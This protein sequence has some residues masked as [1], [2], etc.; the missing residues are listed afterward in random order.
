MMSDM[1]GKTVGPYRIAQKLG[2]GGMGVVYLAEHTL[3]G[4]RAAVKMLLPEFSL[5][6]D[7]VTR[8]FNEARAAT[9]IRHPG[10]VE[11]YDFGFD[12]DGAAF[13]VMEFLHGVSLADRLSHGRVSPQGVLVIAR[14][15]AS[16]LAAAHAA[17]IVHRDL[18]PDNVFLVP[19][20]DVR[21]GERIKLLD[22]GIAKLARAQAQGV[23]QRTQT[24]SIIGTPSYMSPE[25]CRGISVD[26][27]SD[28]YSLGCMLFELCTGTPPFVGEG[29]GDVLSAHIHLSPPTMHS[30]APDTPSQIESLVQ[31]LLVKDPALRISNAE[32][33]MHAVDE[34]VLTLEPHV[35][36]ALRG[37]YPPS[38]FDTPKPAPSS[39]TTLSSGAGSLGSPSRSLA[40][41]PRARWFAF[42]GIVAT[43]GVLL[44][45]SSKFGDDSSSSKE[46]P[47][48]AASQ[49]PSTSR[50]SEEVPTS[51][52]A[53]EPVAVAVIATESAKVAGDT[54]EASVAKDAPAE[55]EVSGRLPHD[56][57]G[58]VSFSLDS[59][60]P[61]AELVLDGR[62]LGKTPYRGALPRTARRL[63]L[64]L[65]LSGYKD[66]KL[67][68]RP[69]GPIAE[70]LTLDEKVQRPDDDDR[71]NSINPFAE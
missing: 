47:S 14:Q 58:K 9:A 26:H 39:L 30:L 6:R 36:P 40:A 11:I 18:K 4:R 69:N 50:S 68:V 62:V 43:A 65:R 63:T 20:P 5:N 59:T 22:F 10:I 51:A 7:I 46:P 32:E 49:A 24:G 45:L 2:A 60:P 54:G 3:L 38:V 56:G 57:D 17:G 21:G 70:M 25:Q 23:V 44:F 13:I 31:R 15:V 12:S 66:R 37:G 29:A 67:V 35:E 8:F 27:R 48:E 1:L 64:T 42:A 19:D 34:A 52:P 16:A 55:G 28:L 53:A 71:D 41:R 33:V 61:G